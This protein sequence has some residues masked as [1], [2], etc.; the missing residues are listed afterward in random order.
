[1]T[2]MALPFVG[3]LVAAILYLIVLRKAGFGGLWLVLV[4]APFVAT[5]AAMYGMGAM[6]SGGP[7]GMSV[8]MTL[9]WLAVPLS[10]IP[11]LLLAILPW[12]AVTARRDFSE[13]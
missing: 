9:P 2:M 11:L 3:N 13:N 8:M 4:V 12:P 6:M 5:I 7:F 10:V 1:M